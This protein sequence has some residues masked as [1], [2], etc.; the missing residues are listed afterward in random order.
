MEP[1]R[2]MCPWAAKN[3][4]NGMITSLGNGMPQLSAAMRTKT[5]TMP[6]VVIQLVMKLLTGANS[7]RMGLGTAS[8]L[9]R[10]P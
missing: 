4:A 7:D 10:L 8:A 2:L 5:S 3:P 6:P 1:V 9:A